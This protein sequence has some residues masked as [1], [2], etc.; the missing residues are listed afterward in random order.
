MKSNLDNL[1]T[2]FI[3]VLCEVATALY[4]LA[5]ALWI[6]HLGPHQRPVS[7][8]GASAGGVAAPLLL[9]GSAGAPYAIGPEVPAQIT[10]ES[11]S[12]N[13]SS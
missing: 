3:T 8:G 10:Q 6:L 1:A 9:S 4:V 13:L 11:V 5:R 12:L 7:T 2:C